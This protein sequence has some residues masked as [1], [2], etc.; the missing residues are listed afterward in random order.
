MSLI[1]STTTLTAAKKRRSKTRF[2]LHGWLSAAINSSLPAAGRLPHLMK[3]AATNKHVEWKTTGLLCLY[4]MGYEYTFTT[5]EI[6]SLTGSSC[7]VVADIVPMSMYPPPPRSK[8]R[9]VQSLDNHSDKDINQTCSL[10]VTTLL[11]QVPRLHCTKLMRPE[12][13]LKSTAHRTR[14]RISPTQINPYSSS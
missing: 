5:N 12:T 9:G 7:C 2:A 13:Q 4:R 14:T 11:I 10:C 1:E 6:H 8:C 3:A